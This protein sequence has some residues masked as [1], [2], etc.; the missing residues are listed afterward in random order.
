V[1]KSREK[2]LEKAADIAKLKKALH[3]P[4]EPRDD[5]FEFS[6]QDLTVWMYRT[7]LI[8]DAEMYRRNGFLPL[9]SRL[10]RAGVPSGP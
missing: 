7:T 3:L 2:A 1:P 10:N 6:W 4:W 9:G 8:N 5:G